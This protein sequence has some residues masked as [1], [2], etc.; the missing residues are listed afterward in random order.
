MCDIWKDNRNLKQLSEGDVE[1]LQ[2]TLKK[3]GTQQVVMSGG[4]A[5]LN[6][7]FFDLCEML[8]KQNI[9]ITVLSTGLAL[10]RNAA[11]LVLHTDDIIVSIDGPAPLHDSIRN[12]PGAF[13]KLKSGIKQIRNIDPMFRITGRCVIHHLNF[14]SWHEI[15]DAAAEIELDQVSFLPADVSSTAF[16]RAT[17][18]DDTRQQEILIHTRDLPELKSMIEYLFKHYD[19]AFGEGFI[20]ESPQKLMK[21]YQHYSAA[22]GLNPYP[23][24]KCN[25]PWVSAVIEADGSVRPCFFHETIGNIRDHSLETILNSEMAIAWRKNLNMDTNQTCIK[26]VCSLNLPPRATPF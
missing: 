1:G 26:C 13:E 3:F 6:E 16:N 10:E 23:Y 17:P 8:K 20:A 9:R 2:S 19:E 21:I 14:R 15:I 18:W 5:L 11:Q 25:A 24:K 12:I 22:N 7:R 4:E